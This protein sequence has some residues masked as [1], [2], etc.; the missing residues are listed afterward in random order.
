LEATVASLARGACR[1]CQRRPGG[2]RMAGSAWRRARECR[3]GRAPR[4][5]L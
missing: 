4:S 2:G 3:P 5:P 1:T